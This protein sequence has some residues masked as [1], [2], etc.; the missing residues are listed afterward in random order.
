[1]MMTIGAMV[2]TVGCAVDT[3]IEYWDWCSFS[4]VLKVTAEVEMFGCVGL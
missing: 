3:V 2:Q 4:P 1:M